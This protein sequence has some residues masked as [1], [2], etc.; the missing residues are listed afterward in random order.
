MKREGLDL[1]GR[2]VSSD[3]AIRKVI[4]AQAKL[5]EAR[6]E[7]AALK[8]DREDLLG[9]YSDMVGRRK[10]TK[11]PMMK[12][13]FSGKD[14][15]RLS[16][17]DLHGMM[18]DMSAVEAFL[19][20]VRILDPDE[21]ILGGDMVECGGWLA[22]HM[23]IGYVAQTTYSYQDD[24][25]ACNWFLDNLQQA[26]P[27]AKIIFMEGNHED[28]VERWCVDQT[29]SHHRDS[30]FLRKAFAPQFLLR[31]AERGIE[32]V[33]RSEVHV[34][35]LPPGWI[36]LGKMYFCHELCGGKS[37]AT[38]AVAK[39]G[40]N[41]TFFHTHQASTATL[42][43]PAVGIIKAFGVGCLC[44]RQPLWRHSDPSNWSHGYAIDI[45]AEDESFQHIDVPIWD[46]KSLASAMIG[47]F[48][49]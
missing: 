41:V 12:R 47:R 40:G 19:A 45:I 17:A 36:K 39:T 20:D 32:Y 15:V 38:A 9:E 24:I 22:K 35:G 49:S 33:R 43:L 6:D 27:H 21:V 3:D 31:L 37:A 8:K 2:E 29:M 44:Q 28:R 25:G 18:A 16:C 23:A 30:E 14:R 26:A 10:P 13:T 5:K 42:V 11:S 4:D 1:R 7:I 46:G 48:K 34:T